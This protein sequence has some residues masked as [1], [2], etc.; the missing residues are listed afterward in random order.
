M[1]ESRRSD[2]QDADSGAAPFSRR[3]P[4]IDTLFAT[5]V[6]LRWVLLSIMVLATVAGVLTARFYP[7]TY[8]GTLNINSMNAFDMLP[9]REPELVQFIDINEGLLEDRFINVLRERSTIRRALSEANIPARLPGESDADFDDRFEAMVF[10]FDIIPPSQDRVRNVMLPWRLRL[11]LRD[12]KLGHAL[13]SRVL[14]LTN[15]RVRAILTERFAFSVA[16]HRR[17][18]GY[19]LADLAVQ[20]RNL[21]ADYDLTTR[22]Q[23]AVLDEQ[24]ELTRASGNRDGQVMS[25]PD[26]L[27]PAAPVAVIDTS[28]SSFIAG[29]KTLERNAQLIRQRTDKENFIPGLIDVDRKIRTINQDQ[30]VIR[31]QDSFE[32]SPLKGTDFQA[33]RWDLSVVTFERTL[34]GLIPLAGLLAFGGSACLLLLFLTL[35]RRHRTA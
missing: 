35:Y 20:R 22:N 5:I 26:R 6:E 29:S 2:W 13:L 8:R 7:Y 27:D 33:V 10:S 16:N 21:V 23:L 9:Y 17:M 14:V 30:T 1:S 28:K 32:R 19:E 4:D 24:I 11:E 15:E 18:R 34:S 25:L 31:A 12:R 3:L